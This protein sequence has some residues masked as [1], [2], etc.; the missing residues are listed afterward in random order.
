[1][2]RAVFVTLLLASCGKADGGPSPARPSEG[3][4]TAP[5]PGVSTFGTV[6]V[7][8]RLVDITGQFPPNKLY[9]YVYVMKYRVLKT[10]RGKIEGDE[11]FVGHYNPLKPRSRAED[12]FSG[13]IGGS[14]ESYRVGDVHH[15]ALEAPLEEQMPMVGMIDKYLIKEKGVRYWA[16]WADRA[17]E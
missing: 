8:A 4:P 16:I 2:T 11:I 17:A 14:V 10:H 3:R 15:L 1:M 5:A 6:E 7:T 9:D 13:R 12:K